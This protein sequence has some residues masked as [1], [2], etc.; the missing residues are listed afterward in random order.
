MQ[1]PL[2][3]HTNTSQLF[4]PRNKDSRRTDSVTFSDFKKAINQ[5]LSLIQFLPSYL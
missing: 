4:S 2:P 5:S 1:D 3:M